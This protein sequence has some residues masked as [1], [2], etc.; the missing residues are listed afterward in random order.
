MN[1]DVSCK[2]TK[3]KDLYKRKTLEIIETN[4]QQ[5]S[6]TIDRQFIQKQQKSQLKGKKKSYFENLN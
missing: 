6:N 4:F 3:K 2:K 1:S 5:K